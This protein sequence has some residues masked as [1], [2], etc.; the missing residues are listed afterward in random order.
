MAAPVKLQQVLALPD[1]LDS[2]RFQLTIPGIPGVGGAD[3]VEKLF[4]LGVNFQPPAINNAQVRVPIYGHHLSFR[5]VMDH[6]SQF[7]IMYYETSDGIV[8]KTLT[9]WSDK[10]FNFKNTTSFKKKGYAVRGVKAEIF[11]TTGAVAMTYK[12]EGVWPHMIQPIQGSDSSA[13]AMVHATF[14]F[15]YFDLDGVTT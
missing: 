1:L 12:F 9:G 14:C 5:G 10:C 4:I 7:S 11:D 3:A 13:P 15:D 6:S 8:S 2:N